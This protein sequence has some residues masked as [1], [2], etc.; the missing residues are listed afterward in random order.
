MPLKL[1]ASVCSW[2]QVRWL[3]EIS[4]IL[5][6]TPSFASESVEFYLSGIHKGFNVTVDLWVSNTKLHFLKLNHWSSFSFRSLLS[7][8]ELSLWLSVI[9]SIFP[10]AFLVSPIPSWVCC[11]KV[12]QS[13]GTGLWGRRK[14]KQRQLLTTNR[15]QG[16][17]KQGRVHDKQSGKTSCYEVNTFTFWTSF[18]IWRGS[19]HN[20]EKGNDKRGWVIFMKSPSQEQINWWQFLK[21]SLAFL[22][23]VAA[24]APGDTSLVV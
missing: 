22:V 7:L 13:V 15:I 9:V 11:L 2:E 8:W 14:K 12:V 5:S 23:F 4:E 3:T 10:S 17:K 21:L 18:F 19:I 1:A 6:I 20:K 24:Q 16:L